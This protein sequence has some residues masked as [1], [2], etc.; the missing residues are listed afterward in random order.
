[1]GSQAGRGPSA[2]SLSL[3]WEEMALMSRFGASR[4]Q[5]TVQSPFISGRTK[6]FLVAQIVR[7]LPA[8]QE[9]QVR[10]LGW[11]DPLRR[12]WSPTPVLLPGEFHGQRSLARLQSMGLQRV[13]HD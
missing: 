12:E 7:N 1:M 4:L 6:A 9:T 11:E 8:M 3:I 10:S 2:P 13:R 5:G